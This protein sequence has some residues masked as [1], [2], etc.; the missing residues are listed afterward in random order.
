M[1]LRRSGKSRFSLTLLFTLITFFILVV[2]V[3]VAGLLIYILTLLDVLP[4]S[5]DVIP[6]SWQIFIITCITCLIAGT[7]FSMLAVRIP[8][9]PF[10]WLITQMNRLAAG[11]FKVTVHFDKPLNLIPVFAEVER[12]FNKMAEEL[13]NT[14][15]LR[16]DFINNFSHEFKTPIVSIAGFAKLLQRGNLTDAERRE[17]ID[18]IA[19]ESMRLSAMATNVLNLTKVENQSILTGCSRFNLSEQVRSAVL[20]LEPKWSA[21]NL[22]LD[23]EFPEVEIHAN[24]ELLKQV[25]IN[26]VDNA[27][28]FSP[29]FGPLKIRISEEPKTVTVSVANSGYISPEEQKRIWNKFY[30]ADKSHSSM[31]NGVGLAI[32]RRIVELHSGTASV[33]SENGAVIFDITLPK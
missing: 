10:N 12:S 15:M 17:Y 11:D 32:V 8:L 7:G 22:E 29:D 27:V 26:L 14:E 5:G 30:Q 3:S 33:T 9:I 24:E 23:M 21:K 1:T 6:E 31:G 4:L 20:L 16:L 18:V 2:T 28:K 25:W 13:E 19:E